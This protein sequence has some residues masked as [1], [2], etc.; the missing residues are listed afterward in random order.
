ML[1]LCPWRLRGIWCLFFLSPEFCI[2][3]VDL[4]CWSSQHKIHLQQSEQDWSLF[5]FWA[6][7]FR[8]AKLQYKFA[9]FRSHLWEK[10]A[11]LTWSVYSD[12]AK[13]P[14][15][16]TTV[17]PVVFILTTTELNC[18]LSGSKQ[19]NIKET[20]DLVC[21][22]SSSV[23][24]TWWF[25]G[26]LLHYFLERTGWPDCFCRSWNVCIVIFSANYF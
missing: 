11:F 4:G 23:A 5:S 20:V 24:I 3:R 16:N 14:N 9:S 26:V 10:H 21:A 17:I 2:F 15:S 8:D 12:V 13:F 1:S 22:Y 25:C 18:S 19:F 7:L 6:A